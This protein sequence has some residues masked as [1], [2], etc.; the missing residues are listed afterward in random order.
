MLVVFVSCFVS[1]DIAV[2]FAYILSV[3]V[4]LFVQVLNLYSYMSTNTSKA[5]PS[6]GP[7]NPPVVLPGTGNN[8][9]ISP[10]QRL[11]PLLECIRD[12]GKEFSDIVPDFQVGR[13]TCILFLSLRYHRLHPEYV[14]Q[15]IEAIGNAYNL[16]ILL[17]LCDI[18]EHQ[19]PIRELTRKC[20]I[21]N[22]TVIVA[23]SNEEAGAYI[24]TFKRFEH[25]PPD[26]IKERVDKDYTSVYR[27]AL[28]SINKVNKTDVETLRSSIGSFADIAQAPTERLQALPGFGQVKV[29][30][31]KEAFERPFRNNAT[32]STPD[33]FS[34][35]QK[36]VPSDTPAQQ[37][38]V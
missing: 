25:K 1:R 4:H 8:I 29:K 11:N 16:R 6:K 10:R 19:E 28:T 23:W 35:Q 15:R 9:L 32:S 17:L 33:S 31:V 12:V 38:V 30:R 34:Q 26:L 13:T 5:G 18:T 36:Q 2:E 20:L 21:N 27:T 14:M 22:I 24:S 3:N 37:D 7:S